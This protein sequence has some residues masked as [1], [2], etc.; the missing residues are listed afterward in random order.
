MAALLN[1]VPNAEERTILNKLN[2][3]KEAA[4][5][6]INGLV[7]LNNY[8]AENRAKVEQLI[9]KALSDIDLQTDEEALARVLKISKNKI[10]E[11]KTKDE[12]TTEDASTEAGTPAASEEPTTEAGTGEP[13]EKK[14]C[15]SA[16]SA[17]ALILLAVLS[18]PAVIRKKEN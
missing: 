3:A 7:D 10:L 16:A 11:V 17:G 13:T 6:E 8:S 9:A 14:G 18:V 1:E 2:A 4:K 12:E 15:Q 5:D